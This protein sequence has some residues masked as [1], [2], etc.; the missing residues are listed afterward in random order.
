MWLV[1]V[2]AG[3]ALASALAVAGLLAVRR[4]P[5]FHK[6]L[7]ENDVPGILF[8]GIGV[9]YGA[10]LGFVVFGTWESYDGAE[11]A[12]TVEAAQLVTVYRD[13]QTFPQS[14]ETQIQAALRKYANDVM[15]TEWAGHGNLALHATPDALNSVWDLYRQYRPTDPVDQDR[16]QNADE[17]L[18]QLEL[19][20]H[21]RHLSGEQTLPGIFWPVLIVGSAVLIVFS[22]FFV[23]ERLRVQVVM[24]ALVAGM[25]SLVL[26]LVYSLNSPFTGPVPVSQQPLQHAL[27]QFD[28]IDLPST[29]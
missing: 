3:V 7:G 22:Y 20:R 16:L 8:G 23:V 14:L 24:T 5:R 29:P 10:L 1:W 11:Q 6:Y 19:Q 18:H 28:A 21:L 4:S 13:S 15:A 9:L 2:A 27:A 25:L 26:F 12:V 17:H